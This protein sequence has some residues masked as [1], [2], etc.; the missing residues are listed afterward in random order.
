MNNDG[1]SAVLSP[2]LYRPA[3]LKKGSWIIA[4]GNFIPFL[5]W[6]IYFVI[7]VSFI[8]TLI[9]DST[10]DSDVNAVNEDCT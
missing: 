6:N 3:D 7:E 9:L 1:D 5:H 4:M 8:R 2:Q 10:T